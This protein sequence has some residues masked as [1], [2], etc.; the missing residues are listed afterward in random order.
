MKKK[1]S[2]KRNIM[3]VFELYP[4]KEFTSNEFY[5]TAR[6]LD[7]FI[8]PAYNT[9]L[10]QLNKQ[11]KIERTKYSTYKLVKPEV[12]VIEIEKDYQFG[13]QFTL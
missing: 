6:A 13:F 5:E 3:S 12:E 11:G 8:P 1:Y 7:I 4:D 9:H 2:A 10:S